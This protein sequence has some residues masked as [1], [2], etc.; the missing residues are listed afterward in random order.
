MVNSFSLRGHTREGAGDYS[1]G[2]T[3]VPIPNTVVKPSSPDDT[4]GEALWDN[5]TLPS[6]SRAGHDKARS[7]KLRAFLHLAENP[8]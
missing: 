8:G 4:A 2:G 6:P 7:R 5:W 1:G 3:P